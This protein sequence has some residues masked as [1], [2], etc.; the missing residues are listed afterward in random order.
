MAQSLKPDN[1]KKTGDPGGRFI[2]RLQFFALQLGLVV[3]KLA[4]LWFSG[5]F[6]E[7]I[8]DI[9]FFCSPKRRRIALS[10][11]A[12][13]YADSLPAGKLHAI[14]RKS[15]QSQALSILELFVTE[16]MRKNAARRFAIVGQEHFD[17]AVARGRGVVFVASH[18]GSWEYIGFPGYLQHFPHAVIV[19][20]V[21]NPY[22]NDAIDALR[23]VSESVPIPKEAN[24][25]RHT[26][27]ELRQNHGVAIII[28]QWAGP[29]GLWVDFCGRAT[30][31]TSLPAKLAQKTGCALVPIFCL[32]KTIG[33]YE[34]H[35]LPAVPLATEADWEARTTQRLNAI[36]ESQIR[37]HPEQWSWSHR[38]WRAQPKTPQPQV[39]A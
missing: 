34:V 27:V 19:K 37:L 33:S 3:L 39:P 30:S 17:A 11:L 31:T 5:W 18:L 29:D 14:A 16:K 7:R 8:A 24:A 12:I 28:D 35:L 2:Y 1:I 36:L 25:L 6:V 15:F 9:Y 23:R 32:R 38:R 4:P 10:N 13:A 20:K 22:I 21:K 26:L